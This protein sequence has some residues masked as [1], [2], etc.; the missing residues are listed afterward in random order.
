MPANP[1]NKDRSETISESYHDSK[2]TVDFYTNNAMAI[3]RGDE[4]MPDGRV[5][6]DNLEK[7]EL[8]EVLQDEIQNS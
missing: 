4:D 3:Y 8:L 5:W 6:M 1:E 2:V 7:R